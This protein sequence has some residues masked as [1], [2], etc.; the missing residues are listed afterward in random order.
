MDKDCKC[1]KTNVLGLNHLKGTK[2]LSPKCDKPGI[3][4][5]TEVIP[6]SMGTSEAGQPFAP[7]N[8][9]FYN[10]LVV[11]QADGGRFLYDSEGN[12]TEISGA[13]IEE[14]K[15]AIEEALGDVVTAE[16]LEA[17]IAAVEQQ[18]DNIK[19]STIFYADTH[20]AGT[21]RHIYKNADM[22]GEA[23]AQ[24]ILDANEKGQVVLR[25]STTIDPSSY[26]DAYL[27]NTYVSTNPYDYQFL[28]LDNRYYY[29]YDANM[30]YTTAFEYSRSEVQLKI[31]PVQTRGTSTSNIMSQN[32]TSKLIYENPTADDSAIRITTNP[33]LAVPA[34]TY[35]VA[36][37]S[38]QNIEA[39]YGG[40]AIG[41]SAAAHKAF[42]IA[43]GMN[44]YSSGNTD[45]G[46]IAIGVGT[47]AHTE[48]TQFGPN[49]AF[50]AQAKAH[51]DGNIALGYGA[52]SKYGYDS[53]GNDLK[54]I[55][56]LEKQAAY[57]T[58]GFNDS[59]YMLIKGVYDPQEDH[60]VAT[61]HYVDNAGPIITMTTTDP[62][63]GA[64][65][66]AGQFVAVYSA[67]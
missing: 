37:G 28:F 61:K 45:K 40:V 18:I 7:K 16:E 47:E 64:P 17:A 23:S 48:S 21:T 35:G 25:M 44:S 24:D 26:N 22:T 67:S 43:I 34:A 9:A 27:Q 42:G 65:L 14:I 41:T 53:L 30:S 2:L 1:N 60:D 51:G 4:F 50:G 54:G 36:I 29:E 8:G 62:G 66:S 46:E 13:T 20:E 10:T 19:A 58:T 39:K 15:Q 49:I 33:Y 56:S 32:A 31:T 63:E 55:L 38:G 11:Y 52:E 12:Y 6:S 59:Q 57:N 3:F 5:T